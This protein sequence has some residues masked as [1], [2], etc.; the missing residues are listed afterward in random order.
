MSTL[1]LCSQAPGPWGAGL[2]LSFQ[3]LRSSD[4]AASFVCLLKSHW[5]GVWCQCQV[6]RLA[7]ERAAVGPQ[8]PSKRCPGQCRRGEGPWRRLAPQPVPAC[9]STERCS[10]CVTG[11]DGGLRTEA[12]LGPGG[13]WCVYIAKASDRLRSPR[14]ECERPLVQRCN[15]H[16]FGTALCRATFSWYPSPL[17]SPDLPVHTF[18][19]SLLDRGMADRGTTKQALF[20]QK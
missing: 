5:P 13:H 4:E 12:I 6:G 15:R 20:S 10:M 19:A 8:L 18:W 1:S 14:I 16:S 11:R 9:Q 17:G 7:G 2:G 3:P